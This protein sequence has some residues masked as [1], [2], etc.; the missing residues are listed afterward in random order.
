VKSF[1]PPGFLGNYSNRLTLFIFGTA[2]TVALAGV[3]IF[4][5][6][7]LQLLN[8]KVYDVV[9][10]NVHT[11]ETTGIPIVIDVDEKSLQEL[12]QWPWPRY[13]IAVLLEK[14]KALGVASVGVDILFSEADRSSPNAILSDLNSD[15]GL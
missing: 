4:Q 3:Q 11:T 2:I 1:K 12:G 14:L 8:G 7:F 15:F 13:R 5:P 10:N 9:L 6:L